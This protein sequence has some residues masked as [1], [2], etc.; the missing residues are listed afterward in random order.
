MLCESHSHIKPD[1]LAFQ[2]FFLCFK[3]T[4][5]N[6][7][8]FSPS[9]RGLPLKLEFKEFIEVFKR[10]NTENCSLKLVL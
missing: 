9:P 4:N 6:I 7:T 1:L 3:T 5:T 2:H 8:F 10:W